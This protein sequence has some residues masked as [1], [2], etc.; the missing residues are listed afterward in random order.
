MAQ[1]DHR[2]LVIGDVPESAEG[3]L[4]SIAVGIAFTRFESP[5]ERFSELFITDVSG[6]F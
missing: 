3:K 5:E 4:S 6:P 1:I 2:T